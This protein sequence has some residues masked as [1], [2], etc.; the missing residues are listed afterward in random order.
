MVQK[1][2]IYFVSTIEVF[3]VV[4]RTTV[5]YLYLIS[6]LFCGKPS[7]ST[8]I[9]FVFLDWAGNLPFAC[10]DLHSTL[11]IPALSWHADLYGF[12]L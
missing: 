9:A 10:P 5:I 6:S 7:L 8:V 3:R 1:T 2:D 11:F 4:E 12:H